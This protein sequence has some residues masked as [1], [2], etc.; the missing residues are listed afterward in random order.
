VSGV[1]PYPVV[2]QPSTYADG[3][4]L[5]S[6]LRDDLTNG[7]LFLANRP[8][9]TGYSTAAPTITSGSFQ[10]VVLNT[11]QSDPWA[12]HAPLGSDP[13]NYYCQAPGWYLAE[14]YAPFTYTGTVSAHEFG[15]AI[16]ATT[17]GTFST[18]QGQLHVTSSGQNPGVFGADLIYLANAG[19]IGSSADYAQLMAYTSGSAIALEGAGSNTPRLSLRWVGT[20]SASALA[21]PPNAAFPVPP[22]Y[23]TEEWLLANVTQALEFLENPPMMRRTHVPIPDDFPSTTWPAG[24][25]LSLTGATLDNYGAW[26]GTKW[27]A[28][29]PGVHFIYGQ[30]AAG[31]T[32]GV[33]AFA[34]GIAVNGSVTWGQAVLSGTGPSD[35]VITSATGRFRLDEGDTVQLTGYQGTG[36]PVTAEDQTKLVVVWESS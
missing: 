23:V 30:V 26:S 7:V 13:Q 17:G 12:G 24:A 29:Q 19:T 6:Q 22:D 33:N 32:S 27:V 11:D 16:G 1:P 8:S 5:V 28:P 31:V 20:G 36:G 15:V 14:G 2:P 25:V 3:P 34:A 35:L 4:L 9:F 21:V 18:H 10:S